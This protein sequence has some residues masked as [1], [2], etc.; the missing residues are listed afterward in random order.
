MKDIGFAITRRYITKSSPM[1]LNEVLCERQPGFY[2]YI[3]NVTIYIV[4][5]N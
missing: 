4:L 3:Y 1:T 2:L 5:F